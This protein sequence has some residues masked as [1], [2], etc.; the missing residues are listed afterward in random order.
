[1]TYVY[2]C[3]VV[4]QALVCITI[5]RTLKENRQCVGKWA[6]KWAPRFQVGPM[7][8]ENIKLIFS[9]VSDPAHEMTSRL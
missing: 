2:Y 7:L 1:M 4:M 3:V 5:I 8:S 9:K 6:S